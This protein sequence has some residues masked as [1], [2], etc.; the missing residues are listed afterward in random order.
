MSLPI[1]GVIIS[2]TKNVLAKTLFL[3]SSSSCRA[4][5]L[6]LEVAAKVWDIYLCEGEVYIL[7]VG[8]AIL[9]QFAAK[10]ATY[11]VEQILPFLLHLPENIGSEELFAN[12]AQVCRST[13]HMVMSVCHDVV[14]D[15]FY[16]G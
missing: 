3:S 5:A 15:G 2:I 1:G 12:I 4:K 14:I 7:C 8:L 11:S 16:C 10:L 6:P 9:K 13:D